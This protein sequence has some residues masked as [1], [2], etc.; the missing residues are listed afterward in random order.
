MSN[1][2]KG[3]K[4]ESKV[5]NQASIK[6]ID[7][8]YLSEKSDHELLELIADGNHR[9]FDQ[10]MAR[11]QAPII[12]YLNRLLGNY[13]RAQEL[14]QETFLR[15]YKTAYRYK[16]LSTFNAWIYKIATNLAYNELRRR[17]IVTFLPFQIKPQNNDES[18]EMMVEIPDED[19]L[20]DESLGRL[21]TQKIVKEALQS[22]PKK[23]K[24]PLILRDIQ[25]LSYEE[26]AGVLNMPLGTVKSR[27]NRA[28]N[29][30]KKKL[31]HRIEDI[32]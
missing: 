11:Y 24:A 25:G 17:K 12:N 13:D 19:N 1:A 15:V 14:A 23:H 3:D 26:I 10:I 18:D 22:L 20:P 28:R 5:R 6:Q 16:F 7:S 2:N 30:L 31:E 21:Q 9:A 29:M 32:L 27:I 8:Q 4:G